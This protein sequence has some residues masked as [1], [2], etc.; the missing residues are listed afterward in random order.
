MSDGETQKLVD[1]VADATRTGMGRMS[2]SQLDQGWQQLE[3]ALDQGKYPSVPIVPEGCA[4][5]AR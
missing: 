1:A 2:A 4:S 5:L 3:R